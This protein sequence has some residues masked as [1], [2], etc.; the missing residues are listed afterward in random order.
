MD[1]LGIASALVWHIAQLDYDAASGNELVAHSIG[2]SDRLSGCWAILPPQTAEVIRPDFFEQMARSGIRA[3]RA[4]PERHRF[5]LNRTAFGGFLDELVERRI[6][7]MLSEM[8]PSDAAVS[9]QAVYALLEQCPNLVCVLCDLGIWGAD[10]Y[11]WPL[12][13]RYEH[14]YLETS[15]LSMEAGGLEATVARFGCERLLFGSGFPARYPEAA[16]LSLMHADIGQADRETI[17]QTNLERVLS[18]VRL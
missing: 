11:S 18:E 14:V 1:G 7:L 2:G 6:P 9:W 3:L 8:A 17:A 12:L 13:E 15:L 10:R 16:M 4:F 5:L